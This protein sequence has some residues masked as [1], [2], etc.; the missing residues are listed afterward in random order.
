MRFSK[1]LAAAVCIG[2][3]SVIGVAIAQDADTEKAI[4][5]YRQ[6]LKEDPWSNPGLLDVDRGEALWKTARG[7]KNVTLEQCDLGKGPGVVEGAF[8]ELPRYFKDADRVMDVETRLLWCMEKLQGFNSADL[9][10]RPHPGGGQP[11]RELGAI[12]TWVANQSAG[13]KFSGKFDHPKEQEAAALGEEL[14][15]RRSGPMDFS[16]ATCHAAE[17]LRIRLQGL[18]HLADSKEA[19]K[20]V[21]EWPAYRVSTAQIMTM[22]HRLYDCFWQMRLPQIQLGSDASVALIAY[23]VKQAQGGEI[24]AP[25]LKR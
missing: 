22:Q 19:R 6:M 18:P 14:F 4:E 5:R 7:P 10:K 15:F 9:V 17:G 13:Q 2:A 11:V 1:A 20:V 24:A 16:C 8:A 12:A 3:L 23:L 21:G 25:G